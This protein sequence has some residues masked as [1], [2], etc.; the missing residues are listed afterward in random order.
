MEIQPEEGVST[1]TVELSGSG[2]QKFKI[3]IA[4]ATIPIVKEVDFR[5]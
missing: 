4:D 1:H 2:V 5:K 3:Y